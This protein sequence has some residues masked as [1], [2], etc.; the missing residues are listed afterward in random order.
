MKETEAITQLGGIIQNL[1]AALPQTGSLNPMLTVYINCYGAINPPSV[2][3]LMFA[4]SELV[5]KEK[6][7]TLYFNFSSTGG[8]VNAGI[9]LYNFLRSLPAR[10]VMHNTGSID[11]VATVIFHAAEERIA[12]PNSTFMFHGVAWG[13]AAGVNLT[14]NQL[15]EIRSGL[16]EAENKIA[17]ILSGRCNLKEEEIRELFIHGE[18]KGTAFALEKGIIQSVRD[19]RIPAEAPF[20]TVNL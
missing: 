14:R 4:C 15:D 13:F 17:Q 16:H 3:K 20:I 5:L 19:P 1:V 18:T 11:S 7:G 8:D 9:T 12:S 6:P 10:I 2:Q